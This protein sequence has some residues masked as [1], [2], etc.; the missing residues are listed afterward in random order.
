MKDHI[1]IF[2]ICTKNLIFSN[3]L[4]IHCTCLEIE[5][6]SLYFCN[7]TNEYE[8]VNNY[9]AQENPSFSNFDK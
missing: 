4:R 7:H 6:V 8:I 3:H 1:I 9:I 2:H 5:T